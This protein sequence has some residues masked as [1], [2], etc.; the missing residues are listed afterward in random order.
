MYEC[1]QATQ[2]AGAPKLVDEKTA[3]FRLELLSEEVSEL[4]KAMSAGDIVEISDALADIVYIVI[5]TA[6]AYNIPLDQVWG[7][8]HRSNMDKID[9]ETNAVTRAPSGKILKPEGWQGPRIAQIIE[10][11]TKAM[12]PTKVALNDVREDDYVDGEE[13]NSDFH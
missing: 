13:F 12:A 10:N 1:D 6:V 11:T 5:G 3:L 4:V 8:V 2:T 7:E 9:P